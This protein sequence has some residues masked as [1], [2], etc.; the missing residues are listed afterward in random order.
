[1]Y[2]DVGLNLVQIGRYRP[3]DLAVACCH[4]DIVAR[5]LTAGA[6]I[7]NGESSTLVHIGIIRYDSKA[8]AAITAMF[9]NDDS[10]MEGALRG[11]WDDV[12]GVL[13]PVDDYDLTETSPTG[14]TLLQLAC[15]ANAI[16]VVRHL[17]T[18]PRCH[19]IVNAARNDTRPALLSA[20]LAGATEIV[21]MLLATFGD[22]IDV[23][24]IYWVKES[25]Q[26]P[27]R[28][29]I[30]KEHTEI[31]LR[32]L[33]HPRIDI[34]LVNQ[35]GSTAFLSACW[36]N[37][38][39]VVERL[40]AMPGL[41]TSIVSKS[42]RTPFTCACCDDHAAIVRVLLD[43]NAVADLN[44]QDHAG[45]SGFMWLCFHNQVDAINELMD[46]VDLNLR[47]INGLTALDY[48]SRH[49]SCG[50]PRENVALLT[51]TQSLLARG[52]T[53]GTRAQSTICRQVCQDD[54]VNLAELAW[55]M[56]FDAL[57]QTIRDGA[58]TG[59]INRIYKV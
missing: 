3:L 38:L 26:W 45:M 43:Q 24:A 7:Y 19:E 57:D 54:E 21:S 52:A 58:F 51:L 6:D 40:L 46:V 55:Y 10:A 15:A 48:V 8:A 42:G 44:V 30:L 14:E 11:A 29:A 34:N 41:D 59:D 35:H 16:A 23:N 36:C 18:H 1:M 27:L 32:L 13:T 33:D 49:L 25:A 53:F 56:H 12:L 4:S 5:L 22:V 39:P 47:C 50:A 2:P 28:E 17:C 37:C 20:V 31:A 9:N